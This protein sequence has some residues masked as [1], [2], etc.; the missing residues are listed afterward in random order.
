M[1]GGRGAFQ[2]A[3][4]LEAGALGRLLWILRQLLGTRALRGMIHSEEAPLQD[5]LT[6]WLAKLQE[7]PPVE[8]QGEV[9]TLRGHPSQLRSG[10]HIPAP[11][12][13]VK[14]GSHAG[15]PNPRTH[16][17]SINGV[18]AQEPLVLNAVC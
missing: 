17:S 14:Q 3:D 10:A 12:F 5:P 9:Q 1:L 15:R 8:S 2:D 7:Q 16:L 6:L 13:F 4:S 11:P 18:D